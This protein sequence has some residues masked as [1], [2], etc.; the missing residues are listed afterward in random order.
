MLLEFNKVKSTYI[1]V[2]MNY[3]KFKMNDNITL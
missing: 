2:R 3:N 1:I